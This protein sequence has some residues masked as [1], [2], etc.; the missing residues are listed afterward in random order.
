MAKFTQA[1]SNQWSGDRRNF[2]KGAIASTAAL[3]AH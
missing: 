3:L 2:L 1:N